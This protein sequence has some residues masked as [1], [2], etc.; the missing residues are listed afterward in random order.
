MRIMN[1]HPIALLRKAP[2]PQ[3]SDALQPYCSNLLEKGRALDGYREMA[4]RVFASVNRREPV[5]IWCEL[6]ATAIMTRR[7][8]HAARSLGVSALSIERRCRSVVWHRKK[9]RSTPD[10]FFFQM[11]ASSRAAVLAALHPHLQTRQSSPTRPRVQVSRSPTGT[12]SH[13]HLTAQSKEHSST[14]Y[15][16]P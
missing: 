7:R 6:G 12:A 4:P 15:R 9:V 5:R 10:S 3:W 11:C 16:L 8:H 14:R 2:E 13:S 1:G